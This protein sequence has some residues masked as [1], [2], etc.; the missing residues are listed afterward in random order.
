MNKPIQHLK[1]YSFHGTAAD[2]SCLSCGYPTDRDCLCDGIL[3]LMNKAISCYL[4][5]DGTE[6]YLSRANFLLENRA[7]DMAARDQGDKN[8]DPEEDWGF[9]GKPS[10]LR[11]E[12]SA[13]DGR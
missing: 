9:G 7:L 11:D 10:Y 13:S 12:F 4:N 8:L 1:Q 6:D 2:G 5:N 3:S